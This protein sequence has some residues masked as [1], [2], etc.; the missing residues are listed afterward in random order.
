MDPRRRLSRSW[1]DIIE[2]GPALFCS[3]GPNTKTRRAEILRVTPQLS[4]IVVGWEIGI[5][6]EKYVLPF[7]R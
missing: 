5:P 4:F 6:T 3:L 7:L 2:K 1:H